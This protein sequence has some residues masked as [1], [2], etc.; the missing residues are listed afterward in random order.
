MATFLAWYFLAVEKDF[1]A[2]RN[3]PCLLEGFF[4]P[5]Y[6]FPLKSKTILCNTK[7]SQIGMKKIQLSLLAFGNIS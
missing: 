4:F 3:F 6:M 2:P 1:F 7:M 5:V